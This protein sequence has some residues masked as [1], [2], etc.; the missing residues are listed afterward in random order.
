[1]FNARCGLQLDG[2]D[3]RSIL[4]VRPALLLVGGRALKSCHPD[5]GEFHCGIMRHAVAR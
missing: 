5:D 4:R 2:R 1:M 3:D